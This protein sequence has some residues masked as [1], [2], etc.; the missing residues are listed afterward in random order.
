LREDLDSLRELLDL[1]V[2]GTHQHDKDGR[3]DNGNPP[4]WHLEV[5][6]DGPG[7]NAPVD[8]DEEPND[9]ANPAEVSDFGDG[10]E[11]LGFE[12]GDESIEFI[13]GD[14]VLAVGGVEDW[15][16]VEEGEEVVSDVVV[17]GVGGGDS[18][19]A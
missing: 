9:G 14:E 15:G 6:G 16:V 17:V 8:N 1:I 3:E 18:G 10:S 12:L 2:I 13:D 19:I 11:V 5:I 7:Q 4:I